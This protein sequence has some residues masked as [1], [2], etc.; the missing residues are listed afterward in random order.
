MTCTAHIAA[1]SVV[2]SIRVCEKFCTVTPGGSGKSV[3]SAAKPWCKT[4]GP[5]GGG[6]S[7]DCPGTV[8]GTGAGMTG[9][10]CRIKT[11]STSR[12]MVIPA[13]MRG[14]RGARARLISQ[15]IAAAPPRMA[16]VMA[17]VYIAINIFTI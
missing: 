12:A 14:A 7:C 13:A 11:M 9:E 16:I 4:G 6:A 2:A 15:R 17:L 1:R 8:V 5:P 3:R 10:V